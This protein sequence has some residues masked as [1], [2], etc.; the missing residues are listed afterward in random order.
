[1]KKKLYIYLVVVLLFIGLFIEKGCIT[2]KVYNENVRDYLVYSVNSMPQD[3]LLLDDDNIRKKDLQIALFDGLV[4][5]DEKGKIVPGLASSWSVSKDKLSYTF[6]I[7]EDARWSNGDKIVPQDFVEF[8]SRILKEKDNTYAHELQCIFGVKEYLEGKK[9]FQQVAINPGKDNILEIRLNYPCDDFIKI[10][11]EPVFTLKRNFYNLKNWRSE[12]KNIDYS[13]AFFIENIYDDGEI[14]LKKNNMYWDKKNVVSNRIH[15]KE[16]K[17]MASTLAQ[18]KSNRI[19]VFCDYNLLQNGDIE[20]EN[21]YTKQLIGDGISLNF[22]LNKD[23][24][25]KDIKFR[26]GIKYAI[27]KEEIKKEL[28]EVFKETCSYLPNSSLNATNRSYNI[29]SAEELLKDSKYNGEVVKIVYANNEDNNKKVINSI[30]KNLKKAKVNVDIQGY[31]KEELK[32]II[33]KGNYDIALLNYSGDSTMPLTY[34]EK[35]V[36][37]SKQNLFGYKN[38]NFDNCILK[39]KVCENKLEAQ[40][41]FNEGEKILLE[42]IGIVPIGFYKFIICRKEYVEGL[43]V[44][45]RGNVILKKAYILDKNKTSH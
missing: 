40:K 16:S 11:S 26:K 22:N 6:K 24:F 27:D 1:M 30:E 12:Y 18:Y 38:I 21:K 13:G 42:D 31:S 29:K 43:E 41:K 32:N 44:N 5:M 3:L 36:S 8:F 34:L 45:S 17:V 39:G 37:N 7:R 25:M 10:L 4:S 9:S 20:D 15:I 33:Y 19:D 23:N 35:W 2:K 14:S 28:G